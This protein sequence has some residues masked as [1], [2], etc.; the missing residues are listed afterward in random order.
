MLQSIPLGRL[1]RYS[2][3]R[4]TL[5]VLALTLAAACQD[6]VA[7]SSS[8]HSPAATPSR[9][10][11]NASS[12]IPDEYIVVFND[13]VGDVTG[14][15]NALLKANGGNLHFTYSSALKGFSAHMSAQAADAILNDP[16]VAYVEQDQTASLAGTQTGAPW[17]LDRIDQALLPG[18][19]TYNYP[20]TGT[21]VNIY[22]I[23]SGIRHT[24][25]QFGGR[26]VPAFSVINDGFGPDGCTTH[27]THVAGAAAAST[28]G[29]A[30]AAM[31]FSVRVTDCTGSVTTSNLI[32]GVDWV[33]ANRTLPAVAN[34]SLVSALSSALNT[35][36]TNSINAG[37]VY[38]AAAGNSNADACNFSPASVPGVITVGAIGGQD[39]RS[40]YS[41]FGSCVDIYAPGDDIYG[42]I[43]TDDV[44]IALGSGT[45]EASAFAAGAAAMYLELNPSASPSQVAQAIVSASTL[46]V[47]T[48]L[49]NDTPN[50]LLR[51][52]GLG[53]G[54]SGSPP[55]PPP[56]GNAAPTANFSASC[57]RNNCTLDGSASSD[58]VG[59]VSYAWNFGDGTSQTST[60]PKTT[61]AYSSKG[62]FSVTVTL[63]VTDGGG[64]TG[65]AQQTLNIKNK[66]K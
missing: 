64:L 51:V 45:S 12:R 66:G 21:G 48:G 56:P 19:G 14:R 38:V 5:G 13:D 28:Y 65:S 36:V 58:D 33:T 24:H 17:G 32:A 18:D 1:T 34:M 15:A 39:A 27:G 42:P 31:L 37:V 40:V 20:S 16:N 43:N 8:L 41:N 11:Q 6:S 63:T 50:R 29:S 54:S 57:S 53:S 10:V 46:G 60:S 3:L 4:A 35:A 9:D 55:P 61:H 22:I 2:A 7:P 23:D 52:T 30:K 44:S 59:I 62:N 49:T 26:V 25:T 47:V